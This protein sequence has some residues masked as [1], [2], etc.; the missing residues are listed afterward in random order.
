MSPARRLFDSSTT[1]GAARHSHSSAPSSPSRAGPDTRSTDCR[2]YYLDLFAPLPDRPS[3]FL[4]VDARGTGTSDVHQ[5]PGARVVAGRLP[6]EHPSCL[7]R[8]T[9][10]LVRPLRHRPAAD[11][12][13]AVS[14][15]SGDR[16]RS[17]CTAT[18]TARS[19][20]SRS[21][22]VTPRSGARS[23]STPRIPSP[24]SI[25]SHPDE[26]NAASREPRAL[27]RAQPRHMSYDTRL[28]W[29][30]S[31]IAYS[32]G[33]ARTPPPRPPPTGPGGRRR[34][35]SRRARC[36]TRCSTRT[37]LP[38]GSARRPPL[39][40][41][42]W[43]GTSGRSVAWSRRARS[44]RRPQARHGVPVGFGRG[45]RS[46]RSQR[47]H[48][49]RT[50]A[51]T[52]RRSA[53]QASFP[54]RESQYAATLAALPASTLAPWRTVDYADSD[55][56]VYEYCLHW[57]AP[58]VPEPPFPAGG[59]YPNVPTLILNGDLD[60]R[61]DVYQARAVARNFPR[62]TYL[63]GPEHRPCDGAV[64]KPQTPARPGSS[65]DSSNRSRRATRA[66]GD[67]SR[68]TASSS[69]SWNGLPM[70]RKRRAPPEPTARPPPT[71]ARRGS[72]SRRSRTSSTAGTR[73]PGLTGVGLYGGKFTMTSTAGLPFT[74]RVWSLKLN[75][76][77]W[78]TDIDVTGTASVPRAAGT[79]SASLTIG[80]QGTAKGD[81]TVSWSTRA[82]QAQARIT[83]TI[84]GRA[85]DLT[86]PAPSHW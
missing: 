70:R 32:R 20:A 47:V 30:G 73:F 63:D 74:S 1:R 6:R 15:R 27:L 5:L 86:R 4:L 71:A 81:L 19:S 66:V 18:R 36:S 35:P 82:P 76:T 42:S 44:I 31:S 69:A 61:T 28:T 72:R 9:R 54:A 68:S 45:P 21:P 46:G 51:L 83:G 60:I 25:L 38:A 17:T 57:P 55:F 85:I 23:S 59:R 34:S 3:R 40:R 75:Q 48:T 39:C 56:F 37:V 2:D 7:R 50:R 11:D 22:S 80:G 10:R 26:R 67:A 41:H 43:P 52:T 84:G 65:G 62:S 29:S 58:G 33:S 14:R 64:R 16:P 12:L 8:A 24:T 77:R 79:A 13:A 78:T 53:Q 49:S